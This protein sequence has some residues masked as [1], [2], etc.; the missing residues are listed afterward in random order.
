MKDVNPRKR[1]VKLLEKSGLVF[2][3]AGANHDV[4]FNPLTRLTIPVK[5][6]DFDEDDMRY[7]LKEAGLSRE[8]RKGR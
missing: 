1:T 3:R 6:H 4:Y 8:D 7:I 2:K 5:R